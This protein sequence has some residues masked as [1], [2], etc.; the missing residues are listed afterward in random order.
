MKVA[1]FDQMREIDRIAMEKYGINGLDL[2][3]NAG[4]AVS[5]N[6]E[7]MLAEIKNTRV[8]VVCGKGNNGG[9]GFV[10]VRHLLNSKCVK[11]ID[12]KIAFLGNIK[13]IKG[14]AKTNFDITKEMGADIFEIVELKQLQKVKHVFSHAGLVIDAIFG[15]GLKGAVRGVMFEVIRFINMLKSNKVLSVDLPSGLYEG[16]DEKKDVCIQADRTVTFGLPKKELL[17]YPG[18]GFTGKLITQDI[19]LPKKLLTDPK[20]K[21]NLMTHSELSFLI[22]KRSINSHKGTFGHVFIIAGSRGLTGAAALASLGALYSGT[23]LVTLGIPES[24]NSTMEMKLTEVMTKPLAETTDG[25]LSKKARKEILDFSSK[26]DAVAIGPG[27]S[28]NSE[29]SSLIR[30][31]IESLE[32]PVVIDADGINALAGHVSMLKKRK[33]P[34]ILTPHPGEMAGLIE[35]HVSEVTSD[36]I[37]IAEKFAITYKTITLL[38]GAG[39][40]IAD[41]RGN[42]Y[43]NPTGNPALAIGGMGD[44]LT[45]LISGLIAQGLSGLDGAKLGAYLHGLAA[46]MWKDENKLDRCLTATELVNYIPKA[47]AR[48]YNENF[49]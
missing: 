24:L 3:E 19:G 37:N 28:R 7:Q 33:Y 9:D 5:K 4:C 21:L 11:D 14:D 29:T 1:S 47:F 10:A 22:P 6:A 38:K 31:L 42:V 46:D 44:V 23:G 39:T 45:G 36:R 26:V 43:I 13:D 18:I 48:I 34:T 20:L 40:I 12:V 49:F 32:K 16:F 35:R 30:E 27:I 2:M 8:L 15:I 41:E 25:S 17:I